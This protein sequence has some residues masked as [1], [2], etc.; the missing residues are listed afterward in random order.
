MLDK[1]NHRTAHE[2][3]IDLVVE[4]AKNCKDV[5]L[6][7][8]VYKL[9]IHD[10]AK[11]PD[12]ARTPSPFIY[13]PETY[14]AKINAQLEACQDCYDLDVISVFVDEILGGEM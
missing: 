10:Q 14:R 9:L 4:A 8:F 5:D 1:K 6:L 12:P 2:G 7:D 11:E 3:Y 13:S